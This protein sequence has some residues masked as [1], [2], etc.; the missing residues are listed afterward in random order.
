MRNSIFGLAVLAL[1]CNK[2]LFVGAGESA[3]QAAR[4]GHNPT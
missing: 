2:G 1:S 3:A 4:G